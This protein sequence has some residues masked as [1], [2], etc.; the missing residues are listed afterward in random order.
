V[1]H[2]RALT[3]LLAL[4]ITAAPTGALADTAAAE[5]LFDEGIALYERGQ[6]AA[7][8]E[9]FEA[10]ESQDVAVGTLLRLG[11]CYERT[12]RLASAWARFREAGSLAQTQGMAD[13]VRIASI[14]SRSLAYRMGRMTIVV[15]QPLPAGFHVELDGVAVSTASFGT[16]LPVDAGSLVL[17]AAAPGFVPI[18]RRV[19]V[20]NTDSARVKVTLPPLQPDPALA[21]GGAP[22]TMVVRMA[23]VAAAPDPP[24][25]PR[26]TPR[27]PPAPAPKEDRGY[28]TRVAGI[29]LAAL[30]GLGLAT[31]GVLAIF[32]KKRNDASRQYCPDEEDV[33]T[34]H[35]L[36]LRHEAGKLADTATISAAVGGGLLATG[37]L[38]YWAAPRAGQS[39]QLALQLEP[40]VGAG[41]VTLRARGSF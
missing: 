16:P 35:G 38:V 7:A 5:A 4:G 27:P 18:E 19:S 3:V 13:R 14:R 6:V 37:L 26:V 15:P 11:D 34:R 32:A 22:R 28:G 41:G 9:K 20:P 2:V 10:S 24:P 29:S 31:S 30:G 8:C 39:E 40:E 23:P 1:S 12:G 33:C 36:E 17:R 25:A 21:T